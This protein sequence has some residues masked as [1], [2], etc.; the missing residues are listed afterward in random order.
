M[1]AQSAWP[2]VPITCPCLLLVEG[3]DEDRLVAALNR[4]L[5]HGGLQVVIYGGQDKLRPGLPPLVQSPGFT[6]TVTALGVVQDGGAHP[7]RRQQSVHDALA[8]AGLPAPQAAMTLAR[9]PRPLPS[10]RPGPE[11]RVAFFLTPGSGQPGM[12]EDLCLASV[13]DDPAME[14]VNG[15]FACLDEKGIARPDNMPKA[16]AHAFLAT[17]PRPD[18]RLGEAAE[19]GIWP[20]DHPAFGQLKEFLRLVAEH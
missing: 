10:G 6:E 11:I 9:G 14:C 8:A 4:Q 16:R 2:D 17:R 7:E 15:L 12:L 13:E 20:F 19:A 5:P 18:L 3:R 1:P